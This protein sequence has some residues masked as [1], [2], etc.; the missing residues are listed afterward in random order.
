MP[1]PLCSLLPWRRVGGR[2]Q[3]GHANDDRARG[4]ARDP[5]ACERFV[6]AGKRG[7]IVYDA[8]EEGAP[9]PW[10][11]LRPCGW[12]MIACWHP[13]REITP[14]HWRCDCISAS[15]HHALPRREGGDGDVCPA[16][17]RHQPAQEQ[18]K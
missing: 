17:A 16:D 13:Q 6:V 7:C 10:V 14:E 18:K 5:K 4:R 15:P 11:N 9:L 8:S 2:V 3:H 12:G 1:A